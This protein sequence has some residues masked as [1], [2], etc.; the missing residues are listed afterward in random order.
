MQVSMR[1]GLLV[2]MQMDLLLNLLISISLENCQFQSLKMFKWVASTM[3]FKWL[4]FNQL[5]DKKIFSTFF[6][7]LS[8]DYEPNFSREICEYLSWSKSSAFL[9][10]HL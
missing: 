2:K 6:I 3:E 5:Q 8:A 10:G 7:A 9:E 1:L 4:E